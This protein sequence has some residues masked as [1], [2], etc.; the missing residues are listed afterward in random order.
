ML[1]GNRSVLKEAVK[2]DRI[3]RTA[4]PALTASCTGPAELGCAIQAVFCNLCCVVLN[5]RS[6]IRAHPAQ[7]SKQPSNHGTQGR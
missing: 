2:A 6:S 1:Q 7:F 3:S 4:T 5:R